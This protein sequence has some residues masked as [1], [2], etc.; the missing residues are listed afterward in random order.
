MVRREPEPGAPRADAAALDRRDFLRLLGVGAAAGLGL[1]S[2]A[3][4]AA[5]GAP[6]AGRAHRRRAEHAYRLRVRAARTARRRPRVEHVANGDEVE[7]PDFIACYTKGLPHDALGR[8]D[9]SAYA[10][11]L[12]CLRDPDPLRFEDI[13]LGAGV[14]L[15]SPQ[16]GLAFDLEGP[17]AQHVTIPPAPR[18]RF[19]ECAGEMVEL[20]WMALLRD[21]PFAAY[22]VDP[23]AQAAVAELGALQDFR[24]P[25]Q[26]GA[27][28]AGT[29]FRGFTAG[30]SI[31][32]WLSQLLWLDVPFGAQR[33]VQRNETALPGV[34][35]L[36]DYGEWLAVQS[37]A[38]R[39]GLDALDPER[40]YV[41]SLR[42][43]GRYVQ[44]DALY[45]AY[46]NACLILL[47]ASVP[48]D[49]G[50]PLQ[51]SATQRGFAEWGGPHVLSLVTEVAT[52]ALK[53]VW[54][55][56]WFVHRRLRPE[57]FGGLVHNHVTGA[58]SAPLHAD[59]LEAAVLDAVYARHGSY[60]LPLAFPEG[61]PTHPS[62]GA[63][64]ATVAGACTTILKAWFDESAVLEDPV[65]P[66]PD[67]T[68]LVPYDGPPLTVG[69][70]LD[71]LASNVAIGRNGAGVH[72]R[73]DYA[74]SLRLG[75]RV[76][77]GIL[78]EQKATYNEPPTFH[79]TT[80]DG[81]PIA[82]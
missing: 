10:A 47:G 32:P 18:L 54:Y 80:F 41:R 4:A 40:R 82:L 62:Y 25:R 48:F 5:D 19:A 57:A 66:G 27:V 37:G 35:H 77:L 43:L 34:D 72:W 67:G 9:P 39:F 52:R 24:G 42:D 45:Q 7:H 46:L 30:D 20:Y 65:V 6:G 36:T 68:A 31:G 61:S 56:K 49:A 26:A 38:D 11:L 1:P 13:P 2:A 14:P 74:E 17:D 59:V 28:T 63:G 21:V 15:T 78:E 12:A 60:L 55:Q 8:V 81:D 29:L 16:A 58:A 73:S 69:H 3:G 64:H 33:I 44:I 71:K 53:A 75:E 79:L 51:G 76:A 22:A 70:E 50:M 23:L